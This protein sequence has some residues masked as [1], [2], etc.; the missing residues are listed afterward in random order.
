MENSDPVHLR[1][2]KRSL[3]IALLRARETVMAPLRSM[4][5]QSGINEQ[6]WRVLR[7]LNELGPSEQTTIAEAACLLLP[8]LTR[9]MASMEKDGFIHRQTDTQDR[10]KT[11]VALQ[12]AGRQ[13]I[14]DHAAQS[15]LI[16]SQIEDSFGRD[17]IDLLLN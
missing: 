15:N 17:K 6:K 4:L 7:V 5:A 13:L 11:I 1:S 16:M 10:R 3:P 2:T 12:D 9:I 14:K 8:S